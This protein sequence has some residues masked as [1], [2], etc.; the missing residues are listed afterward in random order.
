MAFFCDAGSSNLLLAVLCLLSAS[1]SARPGVLFL[2][3]CNTLF[4]TYTVSTTDAALSGGRTGSVSIYRI[5][6][7]SLTFDADP[8][9]ATIPRSGIVLPRREAAPTNPEPLVFSSLQERAK[10]ILVVVIGL[11]FGVGCGALTAATMYLA[12]SLIS[13]G[14]EICCSDAYSEEEEE[15]DVAEYPNQEGYVK[16]PAA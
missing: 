3:P 1:V 11:L 13:H 5:I 8:R 6:K 15:E 2:H 16:I 9:P 10:D 4:V 14:H 12:W 7:P